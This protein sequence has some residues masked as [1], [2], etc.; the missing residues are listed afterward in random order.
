MRYRID[1]VLQTAMTIPATLRGTLISY[2]KLFAQVDIS[3]GRLPQDGRIMISVT[4]NSQ[5]KLVD[6]RVS[7]TPTVRGERI[8]LRLL[9]KGRLELDM[10]KLGFI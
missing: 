3:E 1:G 9:D 5:E 10:T 6:F 7:F 2:I 8:V 4:E